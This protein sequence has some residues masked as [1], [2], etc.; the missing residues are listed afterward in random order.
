MMQVDF[1]YIIQII[2]FLHVFIHNIFIFCN[3]RWLW[4]LSLSSLLLLSLLSLSSWC[5]VFCSHILFV[6]LVS[7]SKHIT[8]LIIGME[9][10][11]RRLVRKGHV[12]VTIYKYIVVFFIIR[13]FQIKRNFLFVGLV[14]IGKHIT[15]LII[16]I[17]EV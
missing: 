7:I 16:G 15:I 11:A 12:T 17:E 14:S 13:N 6:N 10:A 9:E 1:S 2:N 4:L 8:M 5:L 3:I